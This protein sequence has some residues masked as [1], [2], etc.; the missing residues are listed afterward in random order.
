MLERF[1][2]WVNTHKGVEWVTMLEIADDFRKNN[3]PPKDAKM[4]KGFK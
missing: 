1:I 2:T 3:P 4:P